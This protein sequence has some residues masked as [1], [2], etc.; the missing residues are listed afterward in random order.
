MS[1]QPDSQGAIVS[2]FPDPVFTVS[3]DGAENGIAWAVRADQFN[4]KGPAVLYAFDATDLSKPIYESDTNSARDTAGAANKF[5]VP[6][7]TNGKV[8]FACHGEVDVYGLLNGE[9]TAAAPVISPNGGSFSASQTVT[10][11]SSTSSAAIYYTLDGSIPTPASTEYSGPI[12]VSSD[13]TI[14]AIASAAGYIQ[15]S[16]TTANFTFTNQAPAV[17]FTPPAGTYVSAQTV[18]LSDTDAKAKIYFTTDGSA[19]SASSN[20]YSS[21]INV[22][23]SQTI[24]AIAIDSALSNSNV[25]QAAYVIQNGGTSIDFSQGF[26]STAGLTLNGS[27][28]ATN[29]TRLQLTNGGTNQAGSVFWNVPINVQAF[30]TTFQFQL[31]NTEGG[32]GMTFTI[33]G[34]GPTALGGDSAGLGYQDIKKSVAV[35][36]N[37]Y[38]YDN[39]GSD[40][41]GI[42]TNGESPV[43]PTVDISPS[44]IQVGGGDAIQA[45][46]TYD[47]TTLWLHLLDGVTNDTFDWSAPIDIP[48]VIGANSAYVGF[49]G[50]TG[51]LTSSQKLLTWTYSTQAV[52]PSFAPAAGTYNSAQSVYYTTDGS[53]P[54]AASNSYSAPISVSTSET[55]KAIA[56]SSTMGA[57]QVV[58]AAYTIQGGGGG[59]SMFS[60]SGTGIHISS[61][62]TGTSTITVTPG[63]GF[64]GAVK[65][66]CSLTNSPANAE[67]LPTCSVTQPPAISGTQAVTAK[68]T[69]NTVSSSASLKGNPLFAFGGG[70]TLAVL[71]FVWLPRRRRTWQSLLGLLLFAFVTAGVSGCSNL[72]QKTGTTGTTAGDYTITV[73]GT[74][75]SVT[76]SAAVDVQVK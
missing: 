59:N 47:G 49:T 14:K 63:A 6:V 34:N 27:A 71:F 30:T 1:T 51:G 72:G 50:G 4:S 54:T 31:S 5:S 41:T 53:T 18:T 68:L 69:V 45:T 60:V 15:S 43:L 35:K 12:N 21:P 67:N 13:T 24:K 23:I 7:V 37:F 39:E 26:S 64:T 73:T 19:P 62:G 33:Q 28:V 22:K 8:Y 65:L 42:Y 66:A 76:A 52:A 38:N 61:G 11:S 56:I 20:L 9:P 48:Q 32:N 44:G 40:S 17:T 75:G 58:T 57:S 2:A 36:F 16:V 3:S 25:T 70:T 74:S 10:M 55:I 46:I 29:D